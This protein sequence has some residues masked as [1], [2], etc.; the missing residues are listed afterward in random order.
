MRKS[1]ILLLILL[2]V[3]TPVRAVEY[4]APEVPEN[5]SWLMETPS[6]SFSDILF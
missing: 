2:M 5:A 3:V 4:T 1:V 6:D